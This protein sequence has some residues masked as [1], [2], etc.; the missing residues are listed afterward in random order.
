MK[1][2]ADNID[3]INLRDEILEK[4]RQRKLEEQKEELRLKRKSLVELAKKPIEK[5]I[6]K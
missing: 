6:S 2:L 5:Q 4:N 1:V 3:L